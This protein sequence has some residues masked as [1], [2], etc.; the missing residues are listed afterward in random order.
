MGL[1]KERKRRRGRSQIFTNRK[2]SKKG[3]A[4]LLLGIVSL[5]FL[6]ALF[7]ISFQNRGEGALSLGIWGALGFLFA[8]VALALSVESR[9]EEGSY[10]EIPLASL[11]VSGL[12]GIIW[13]ILYV[14]GLFL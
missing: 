4:G 14:M 9:K 13:L 5:G 3:V 6:I 10:Q 8:L 1:F 7:C 2:T 12:A 11:L